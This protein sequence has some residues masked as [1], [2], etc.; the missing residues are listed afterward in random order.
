MMCFVC[1]HPIQTE[2]DGQRIYTRHGFVSVHTKACRYALQSLDKPTMY[3]EH[4]AG[5]MK[6]QR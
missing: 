1:L 6:V 4:V 3:G 2:R 5:E